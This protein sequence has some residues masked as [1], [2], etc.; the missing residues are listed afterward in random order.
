MENKRKEIILLVGIPG[1]GK[2]TYCLEHESDSSYVSSD[3]IRRFIYGNE[4]I[5]GNPSVVFLNFI[6]H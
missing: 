1:S 5:Q 2:T 4:S 3:S 6:K